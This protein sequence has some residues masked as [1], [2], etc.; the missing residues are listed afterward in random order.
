VPPGRAACAPFLLC[1]LRRPRPVLLL[2]RSRRG[3]AL[4]SVPR[5]SSPIVAIGADRYQVVPPSSRRWEAGSRVHARL[6]PTRPMATNRPRNFGRSAACRT[7][8]RR[9]GAEGLELE[10]GLAPSP[11]GASVGLVAGRCEAGVLKAIRHAQHPQGAKRCLTKEKPGWLDS[12]N[13]V[14]AGQTRSEYP[15]TS[16]FF[17]ACFIP[18]S[19]SLQADELAGE[20]ERPKQGCRRAVRRRPAATGADWFKDDVLA[21]A[22]KL[23]DQPVLARP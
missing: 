18:L 1:C 2:R 13:G 6:H 21:Y 4:S 12:P 8:R 22:F 11:I 3:Y 16:V 20:V 5:P 17:R 19:G 7:R 15:A 23:A 10:V 9:S 14:C